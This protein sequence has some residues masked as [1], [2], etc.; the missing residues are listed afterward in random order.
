MDDIMGRWNSLSINSKT[1]YYLKVLT[2]CG[3]DWSA[4]C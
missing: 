1:P 3:L 2:I 4:R